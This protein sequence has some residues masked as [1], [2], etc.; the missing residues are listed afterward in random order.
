MIVLRW[1]GRTRYRATWAAQQHHRE[2][3]LAGRAADEL[4]LLEHEPVVTTGRRGVD[5]LDPA[6]LGCEVVATE[7]GGL[8][9]WH[10]PGQLV[11]YLVADV[12]HL[13]LGVRSTVAAVEQGVLDWLRGRG[14]DADRRAGFPGVWVGRDKICA[15]GMHFRR[16]VSMHGFALNLRP[17]LAVYG[18][19]VP[20]GVTDG[21]VTSLA[22][23]G[24]PAPDPSEVWASVGD[25]V[26]RAIVAGAGPGRVTR[27]DVDSPAGQR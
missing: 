2:E 9:T 14:V 10:G 25:S 24:L 8:A 26:R 15:V 18:R 21:G 16:G 20:C 19:F 5:G 1:L 27:S 17:D 23:L 4:W 13:G 12:G 6:A 22:A 7:R 3:L 11:G